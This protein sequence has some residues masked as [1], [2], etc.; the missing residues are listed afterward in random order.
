MRAMSIAMSKD[1]STIT[2]AARKPL[3]LC[4]RAT[5][6]EYPARLSLAAPIAIDNIVNIGIW[7]P[8]GPQIRFAE[9]GGRDM[10]AF[11]TAPTWRDRP[12]EINRRYSWVRRNTI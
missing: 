11:P 7:G 1:V 6:T 3:I 5:G 8:R 4:G 10:F 9:Q 12:M 2:A